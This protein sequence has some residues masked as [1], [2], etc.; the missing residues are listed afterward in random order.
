M[1]FY[2]VYEWWGNLQ[3]GEVP[4]VHDFILQY[5][6]SMMIFSESYL[7]CLLSVNNFIKQCIVLFYSIFFFFFLNL[8]SDFYSFICNWLSIIWIV[9]LFLKEI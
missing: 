2:D 7:G 5:L 3:E 9:F 6:E 8:V 4:M 1:I